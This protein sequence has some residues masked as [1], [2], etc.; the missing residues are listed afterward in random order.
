VD[1]LPGIAKHFDVHISALAAYLQDPNNTNDNATD[2]AVGGS[3]S[4]NVNVLVAGLPSLPSQVSAYLA[5]LGSKNAADDR[6]VIWIGANDFAAG[7]KPAETIANIKDAI[8]QLSGA[9]AKNFIV[10]TVPDLSLTPQIKALNGATILAAKQFTV[11]TNV[12]LAVELPEFAFA[13]QISIDLVDINLIFVPIVYQPWWFG[14]A[15][16]SGFAYVPPT[17]PVLV[18]NPNKYVFWDGFHP[19]TNVHHIAA[20]FIFKAG[21]V[22]GSLHRFLS[23][24]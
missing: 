13:H 22:S 6:C 14:F 19:T 8:A 3:T 1:Y 11:A 7:I 10:I 5:R 4:G 2:F 17:G 20:A 12:L 15:N 24:R 21:F 18:Q 9:G 16:S 23:L